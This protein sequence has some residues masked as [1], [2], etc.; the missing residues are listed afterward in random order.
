MS[1]I[2]AAAALVLPFAA[3]LAGLLAPADPARAQAAGAADLAKKLSNPVAS[4]ISVPIQTNYDQGFGPADGSRVLTNIQPVYPITL[5]A[6][7]NLISR[8]I[9]PV[10]WQEDIAGN[11]GVQFGLGDVVQSLFL[12]PAEPG[13]N[14]VIWGVGPVALLPTAT[15]DLLGSGKFGLG[16]TAVAL[17]QFG[18]WTLGFLGNHIW[19]VAGEGS[20][21]DVNA[22]FMQPFLSYTTP[23]AWTFTV[24]TETTY[25]W[26][27]ESWS[28][29]LNAVV[30]KVVTLGAQPVSL[31]AGARYWAEAPAGGP[32]GLGLRIGLTFLFPR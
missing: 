14:G 26:G 15:D 23:E 7:W 25:D 24:N 16:P 22:T 2:R 8:T 19:S 29:P 27:S 6:D 13:S 28:V 4:L 17:K 1:P 9:L 3:A 18:P 30:S 12:S 11:S 5:S 20:R 10:I 32:E 31:F 21:N